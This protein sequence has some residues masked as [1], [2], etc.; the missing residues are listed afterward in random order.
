MPT[1]VIFELSSPLTR[2]IIHPIYSQDFIDRRVYYFQKLSEELED[3]VYNVVKLYVTVNRL[4]RSFK[5]PR[6]V[7]KLFWDW[8]PELEKWFTFLCNETIHEQRQQRFIRNL[9]SIISNPRRLAIRIMALRILVRFRIDFYLK[10]KKIE[11]DEYHAED[12]TQLSNCFNNN[13]LN[14]VNMF[15]GWKKESRSL[16]QWR[17]WISFHGRFI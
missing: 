6:D 15:H 9:K 14:R 7:S 8:I 10:F 13:E 16:C 5:S 11:S 4:E 12:L 3:K 1:R 17:S 2:L